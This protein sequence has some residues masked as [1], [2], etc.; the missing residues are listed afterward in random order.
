MSD[1]FEKLYAQ[2]FGDFRAV[3]GAQSGHE[4]IRRYGEEQIQKAL[5]LYLAAVRH[6]N[7]GGEIVFRDKSGNEKKWK[8]KL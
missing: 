7:A 2:L 8:P 3:R 1:E 4:L 6:H 5:G